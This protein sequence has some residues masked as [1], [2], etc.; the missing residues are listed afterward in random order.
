MLAIY[1]KNNASIISMIKKYDC[2]NFLSAAI[3]TIIN[4]DK[5]DNFPNI[6]YKILIDNYFTNFAKIINENI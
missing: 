5:L 1:V 3:L 4:L 6:I 2:A